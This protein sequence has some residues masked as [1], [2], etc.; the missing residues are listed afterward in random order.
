MFGNK[1]KKAFLKKLGIGVK[2]Q[3]FYDALKNGPPPLP[4]D[5][6]AD[7]ILQKI[8]NR[9]S[10]TP[11]TPPQRGLSKTDANEIL[12]KIRNRAK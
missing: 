10:H 9:K 7:E 3:Q 11:P 5:L 6:T 8:R 4:K 12:Q 1:L 2:K